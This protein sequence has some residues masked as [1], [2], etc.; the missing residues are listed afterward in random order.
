MS[1]QKQNLLTISVSTALQ[2]LSQDLSWT[3]CSHLWIEDLNQ[4]WKPVKAN[5][6][7]SLLGKNTSI[8]DQ[9]QSHKKV[10][11]SSPHWHFKQITSGR[12][13]LCCYIN[14][15]YSQTDNQLER[16]K[17]SKAF[18]D[19][20]GDEEFKDG[21]PHCLG[22]SGALLL[23]SSTDPLHRHVYIISYLKDERR[24]SNT[25]WLENDFRKLIYKDFSHHFKWHTC[26]SIC[27]YDMLRKSTFTALWQQ[28]HEG[29]NC[30][31]PTINNA[32]QCFC[33]KLLMWSS[34]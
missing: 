13:L 2:I 26:F 23:Q 25:V 5:I 15:Y 32:N 1:F 17:F 12:S 19:F 7:V 27:L 6:L 16:K 8:F 20:Q 4:L 10:E 29:W 24:A 33:G 28:T 21:L 3:I 11:I 31:S 22:Q 14:C 9:F 30:I 34:L 18:E